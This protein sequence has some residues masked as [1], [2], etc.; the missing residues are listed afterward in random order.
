MAF[1]L[2]AATISE[3]ILTVWFVPSGLKFLAFYLGGFLGMVSY[4]FL[5]PELGFH[6]TTDASRLSFVRPVLFSWLN[7]VAC[8][9]PEGRALIMS[10]MMTAGYCT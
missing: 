7:T 5:P 1:G 9:D 3:I 8:E 6:E 4:V 2:G 10:S